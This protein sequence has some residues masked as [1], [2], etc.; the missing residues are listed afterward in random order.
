MATPVTSATVGTTRRILLRGCPGA[1]GTTT[2]T[3]TTAALPSSSH[4]P[5]PRNSQPQQYRFHHVLV[6][7]SDNI[8]NTTSS[9]A[10][11]SH[12]NSTFQ[13]RAIT[14]SQSSPLSLNNSTTFVSHRT[15]S[16]GAGKRDFYEVLGVDKKA[17]KGTIK[18]AYFQ[19]AKKYHPDTNKVSG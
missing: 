9:L 11:R 5:E 3:L 18:K 12:V 10:S 2:W 8:H 6:N 13:G 19:L 4:V 7:R 1:G 17:D 16:S 15:F 14:L